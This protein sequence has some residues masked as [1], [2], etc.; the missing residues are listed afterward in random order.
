MEHEFR[1]FVGVDWATEE[2]QVYAMDARRRVLGERVVKHSG[3]ALGE[4]AA[5]LQSLGA[6]ETVAVAI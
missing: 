1:V 2:H 5:W 3:A 4:L 6:P